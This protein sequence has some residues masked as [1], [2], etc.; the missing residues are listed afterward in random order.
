M[1]HAH[2]RARG[3]PHVP[4]GGMALAL[5]LLLLLIIIIITSTTNNNNNSTTKNNTTASSNGI[6]DISSPRNSYYNVI[7]LRLPICPWVYNVI[8]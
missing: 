3:C 4:I 5:L 2:A 6:I 8:L 1:V 7:L